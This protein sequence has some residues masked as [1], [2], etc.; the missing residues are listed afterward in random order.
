MLLTRKLVSSK[1]AGGASARSA[2]VAATRTA[3]IFYQ[4]ASLRI[5]LRSFVDPCRPANWCKRSTASTAPSWWPARSSWCR[6]GSEGGAGSAKRN[7]RSS[8]WMASTLVTPCPRLSGS[9]ARLRRKIPKPCHTSFRCPPRRLLSCASCAPSRGRG[10][11]LFPG[12][13]SASRNMSDGAVNAAL[14]RIGYK[15]II[16]GHGFR[17]MARTLLGMI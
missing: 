5:R 16:T 2:D 9:C 7:G 11:F 8:I 14:T 17:H 12:A 13:R 6:C 10:R 3:T 1:R 4:G 15:G